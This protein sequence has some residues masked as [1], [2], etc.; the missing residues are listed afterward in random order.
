MSF[1]IYVYSRKLHR[2]LPRIGLQEPRQA[3]IYVRLKTICSDANDCRPLTQI[4]AEL[5]L[6]R[7]YLIYWYP[8]ECSVISLIHKQNVSQIAAQRRK[9][10]ILNGR[11][12]TWHL[13]SKGLYPSNRKVAEII[14]PLNFSF[15]KEHIR[16]THRKTLKQ[17][18][19]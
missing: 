9:D 10:Q 15:L 6:T 7:K 19:F 14:A 12:I 17:L 8:A 2:I 13:Y 18:K 1:E 11:N 4:T 5:S 3:V 16:A